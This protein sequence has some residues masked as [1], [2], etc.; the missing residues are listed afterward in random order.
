MESRTHLFKKSFTAALPRRVLIGAAFALVLISLFVMGVDNPD[1]DWPKSWRIRPIV[2][3]TI[4]GGIGGAFADFMHLL[5]REGGIYRALGIVVSLMGY[6][7]ILWLGS[8]LGLA[9]TLWD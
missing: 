1:P 8:V 4:A 5:R 2:V 6:V 7:I 9:G 3:T